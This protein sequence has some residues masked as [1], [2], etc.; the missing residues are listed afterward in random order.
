MAFDEAHA[1]TV[2]G[3]TLVA[4]W[5]GDPTAA[6]ITALGAELRAVAQRSQGRIFVYNIITAS[7]P[8]PT[9][10]SLAALQ[11]QFNTM[12]GQL[13]ALAVVLEKTGVEGTLSRAVLSTTLT[14]T[15]QPFPLRIFAQRRDGA[16]WLGSQSCSIPSDRLVSFAT[17]LEERLNAAAVMRSLSPP[18]R[19]PQ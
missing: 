16:G 5:K 12:R 14:V 11:K 7:T 15:R 8:V 6:R 19:A 13:V 4:L 9:Y 1:T 3:D 2:L 10:D 18:E 17:A